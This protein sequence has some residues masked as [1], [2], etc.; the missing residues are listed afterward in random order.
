MSNGALP[1]QAELRQWS[2]REI[3][4]DGSVGL[5][6][7]PRLSAAVIDAKAPA[8][9]VLSCSR[10]TQGRYL[11]G[12]RV[13]MDVVMTCQRC[14]ERCDV[15]LSANSVLA[16]VWDDTA[17]G[18]LPADYDPLVTGDVTDL[19]ELVE[20]ELL[21]AVPAVAMHSAPACQAQS[22]GAEDNII[23]EEVETTTTRPFAGLS[24][25]LE[26]STKN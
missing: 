19:H 22:D 17:A 13:E 21:L 25:L 14:L 7:M 15:A 16:C 18:D 3:V 23:S 4:A 2:A 20:D 12:I 24:E 11:V 9:A 6:K 5:D 10:D 26:S 1:R 8:T